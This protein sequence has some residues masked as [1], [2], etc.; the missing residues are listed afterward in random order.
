[1]DKKEITPV[2][3]HDLFPYFNVPLMSLLRRQAFRCILSIKDLGPYMDEYLEHLDDDGHLLNICEIP[4]DKDIQLL[5]MSYIELHI[6]INNQQAEYLSLLRSFR[7]HELNALAQH[8][9]MFVKELTD[10]DIEHQ[11]SEFTPDTLP[12]IEL[13]Y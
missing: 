9:N 6:D 4:D 12:P 5:L 3:A 1:M 10:S 13:S 2:S 7:N 8:L 11:L